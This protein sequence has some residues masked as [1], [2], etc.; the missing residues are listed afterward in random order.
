MA[1]SPLLV[2]FDFTNLIMS[3]LSSG[4]YDVENDLYSDWKE[5]VVGANAAALEAK[6]PPAFLEVN[7][8]ISGGRSGGSIGGNPL[9]NAQFI[10][11]YFFINNIDGWRVRPAEEDGETTLNGNIFPLDPD[12]A[13]ILPTVGNFTQLL[14][15]VV[16]PQSIVTVASVGGLST[17]QDTKLTRIHDQVEREIHVDTS[18]VPGSPAP[19]GSQQ[20]P[21]TTFSE[22]A[23]HAELIGVHNIA[24][25]GDSVLDRNMVKFKFRGEG[26]PTL[27]CAGRNVNKAHFNHV[28]LA[29]DM[30]GTIEAD[31]CSLA[32]NMTGLDGVF[33]R[34]GLLGDLTLGNGARVIFADP[35]SEIPGL[36]RPTIDLNGGASRMALRRYSG[37]MTVLGM[38]HSSNEVT[39]ESAGGKFTLDSSCTLGD[40]SIRGVGHFEDNSIGT[41]VDTD[42]FIEANDITFIKG[43]VGGDAIVSVDDQTV[44]VYDNDVSPRQTLAVYSI[45]ADGRVRTRTV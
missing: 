27:D 6:V 16:S 38:N 37:G 8:E 4:F 26:N 10:A 14:K 3:I 44:T 35:F 11:P 19:N 20:S 12:T 9:G 25:L 43:L 31:D 40:F 28:T 24:I 33:R 13:F 30:T 1:G 15:I 18:L 22:A 2:D 36:G 32:H 45:S 29:G 17:E 21:W 39:V 5:L 34:C 41:N 7:L 23:D 42:G